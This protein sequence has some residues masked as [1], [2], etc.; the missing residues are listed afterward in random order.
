MLASNVFRL[1]HLQRLW[2]LRGTSIHPLMSTF[3]LRSEEWF[4]YSLQPINQ[5]RH[6]F[7]VLN[8]DTT[9]PFLVLSKCTN[10]NRIWR[11]FSSIPLTL[12]LVMCFGI[13]CLEQC[14]TIEAIIP[15]GLSNYSPTFLFQKTICPK[16]HAF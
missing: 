8:L 3:V 10:G 4:L 9:M 16:H 2:H 7:F 11:I 12:Y 14:H 15:S 13:R 1:R 5:C 6:N